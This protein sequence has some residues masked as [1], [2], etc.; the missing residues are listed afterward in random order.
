MPPPAAF[1][2]TLHVV[3]AVAGKEAATPPN[4]TT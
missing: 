2:F 1:A 3:R 4:E